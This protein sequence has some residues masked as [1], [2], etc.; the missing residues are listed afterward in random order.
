MQK[1]VLPDHHSFLVNFTF[2]DDYH[3]E[4]GTIIGGIIFILPQFNCGTMPINLHS[5]TQPK[6]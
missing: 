1:V 4:F 6:F 3:L 5:S 2:L